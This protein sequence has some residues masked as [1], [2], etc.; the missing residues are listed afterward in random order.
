[1]SS[2]ETER[3]L[4][5]PFTPA[6]FASLYAYQSRPDVTRYL[7]WDARTE[8]Q[9]REALD[10]KIAATT[11]VAEGDFLALAV[12]PKETGDVWVTSPSMS[13]AGSTQL[14]SSATSSIQTTTDAD[15]RPRAAA[16]S[17]DRVRGAGLAPRIGRLE[18][19]NVASARVLKKLGMRR[20]AHF[21]EN[22][23][24]KG[25]WQSEAVYAIPI[26]SGAT[27][28][29]DGRSFR[30]AASQPSLRDRC[31]ARREPTDEVPTVGFG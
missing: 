11:I 23:Y 30:E 9:V 14:A 2:V 22:E 27:A 21:V 17:V 10:R 18:P 29:R 3:L 28:P 4:L 7:S 13:S 12:E 25:E 24:L 1:M 31:I 16:R 5:R 15:M 20:E 8:D 26:A 6:D 19:R